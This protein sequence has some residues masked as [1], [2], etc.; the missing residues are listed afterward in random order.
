MP[1]LVKTGLCS[2][3]STVVE[4]MPCGHEVQGSNLAGL[5]SLLF[6]FVFLN[7]SYFSGGPSRYCHTTSFPKMKLGCD[8]RGMSLAMAQVGKAV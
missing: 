4:R 3:C 8:A 7:L 5:F 1:D 2:G 6:F